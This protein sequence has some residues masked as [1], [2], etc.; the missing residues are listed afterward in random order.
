MPKAPRARGI[1]R[2]RVRLATPYMEVEGQLP[3]SAQPTIT[4]ELAPASRTATRRTR[5]GAEQL[6]V[7]TTLHSPP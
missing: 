4:G 2:G 5:K 1:E 3:S 7:Q 6:S